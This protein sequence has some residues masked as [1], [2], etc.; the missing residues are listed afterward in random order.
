MILI[1]SNNGDTTT[2][3]VIKYL[4]TMGKQFIRIHENEFFKIKTDKK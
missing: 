1:I 3:Q 2:I 4:S